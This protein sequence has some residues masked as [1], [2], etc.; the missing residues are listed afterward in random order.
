[1]QADGRMK[2]AALLSLF[3]I[4]FAPPPAA[5]AAP[6]GNCVA[7][8]QPAPE[9]S[10]EQRRRHREIWSDSLWLVK[11]VR[12][13][14]GDRLA[15]VHVDTDDPARPRLVF[16]VTGSSPLPPM[17]LGA[18]AKGVPVVV[19][20]GAPFSL[21]EVEAIRGRVGPQVRAALPELQGE[22]YDERSGDIEL[23][24]YAPDAR[25]QAE[26]GRQCAPLA[27]L[28]GMPVRIVAVPARAS[29]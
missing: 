22:G 24:V 16:R 19:E 4:S 7:A 23:M 6:A 1:M 10:A 21:G 14:H 5:A 13:R 11:Q 2:A 26:A 20:Y 25:A 12:A 3:L 9:R 17:R 8:A 29:F 18:R 28:Y 27:R 15:G